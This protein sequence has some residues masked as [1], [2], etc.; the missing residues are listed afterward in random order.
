MEKLKIAVD[1]RML[2]YSG[3][4]TFIKELLPFIVNEAGCSF[5]LIGAREK[6]PNF[7]LSRNNVELLD[8]G[9]KP[10][11]AGELL[12]F[13]VA[14]V[15]QCD[16]YFSPYYNI[17]FGL[18]IPVF[19]SIHDVVFLDFKGIVGRIGLMIRRFFL[20]RACRQSESLFTVSN[21]SKNRII[22]HFGSH[23]DLHVVYNGISVEWNINKPGIKRPCPEPY[24]IFVG[25]IKKYKGL[26]IL[27]K[28]WKIARKSGFSK[29]L[30]IIGNTELRTCDVEMSIELS[31]AAAEGGLISGGK[32][33][34]DELISWVSNA[35]ALVFPSRYEGFGIPPLE[36]LSCGT[37][38]IV[39]DIPVLKEIYGTLP[40]HFFRDGDITSL[41][42]TLCEPSTYNAVPDSVKDHI[43]GLY[44][45]SCGA[46]IIID[47]IKERMREN[48]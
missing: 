6:I 5:L 20:H 47:T 44:S 25:N 35:D 45:Y 36:A 29:K 24:V 13:P 1:C 7:I 43:A 39:S 33:E 32:L 42:E 2:G 15:N 11:S 9:I 34:L 4:G 21:F 22:H 41:A 30:V 3:I 10:F 17:P 38:A 26:D 8:C 14:E 40:V 19:S 18:K 37:A 12:L 48:K 23:L 28:A 16:A 46:R 27:L 31:H